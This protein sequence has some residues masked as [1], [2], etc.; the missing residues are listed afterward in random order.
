[1]SSDPNQA[2]SRM[3][4]SAAERWLKCTAS[5]RF[6]AGMPDR[7]SQFAAEGTAAHTLSEWARE[8]G[9]LCKEFIG[10]EIESDGY[11]FVVDA[12]MAGHVQRFVDYCEELPG[13][14]FF[15]ERVHY[16][17]WVENGWGT[18]DDIRITN[19]VCY[20]TDLKYGKGVQKFAKGNEQLML[21]ALGVFQDY[22]YLYDFKE[23]VIAIHQPRLDH[24]DT[25]RIPVKDL[26]LWARDE[27]KPKAEIAITGDGAEFVAGEHCRFCPGRDS[28]EARNEQMANAY[29]EDFE[30]GSGGDV[31][32]YKLAEWLEKIPAI[33]QWCADI[34]ARALSELQKGNPVGDYKLVAGRSS[35]SWAD[36]AEAEKALRKKLKVKEIFPTK[37][38]S[39]SQAEKLLGKNNQVLEG[40]VKRSQGK[41]TMVP[42]DDP[43]SAYQVDA[44]DDFSDLTQT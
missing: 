10:R 38:I 42:G 2:H 25:H 21:Y 19:D 5:V 26:L 6:T 1:M 15:E 29:I 14:A 18:A 17:A 9:K 4:P 30:D 37:M 33:R 22:G 7:P 34:E 11:T 23:M 35:R 44:A 39:P 24:I 8:E 40:L 13:E 36:E 41:P 3:G 20:V 31:P 28:C 43:R 32:N 27:V 16:T 12:E